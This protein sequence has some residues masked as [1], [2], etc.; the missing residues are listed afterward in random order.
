MR[1]R[2]LR[3]LANPAAMTVLSARILAVSS[4]L[5]GS[6]DNRK[7]SAACRAARPSH[8]VLYLQQP[9]WAFQIRPLASANV[10][11]IEKTTDWTRVD[12]REIRSL[13]SDA[14]DPVPLPASQLRWH[15][16]PNIL[17]FFETTD[18][19]A[20]DLD[21]PASLLGQHRAESAI[22]F[23]VG[24]KR[25]GYN[26]YVLGPSGIGKQTT[27][28]KYLEKHAK[29]NGYSPSDWCYVNNFLTADKPKF[30][31]LPAGMGQTL[32]TDVE[33]LIEDVK[34]AIP[35][36][37]ESEEHRRRV[38]EAEKEIF[39]EHEKTLEKL[40]AEAK[41]KGMELIRRPT[42]VALVIP[43]DI[44]KLSP[45]KRKEIDEASD[46]LQP[47][48]RD[49]I[50]KLPHFLKQAKAKSKA[51]NQESARSA[52]EVIVSPLKE[53]Y[54]NHPDVVSHLE[55]V[56]EDVVEHCD[57]FLSDDDATSSI[58]SL[59]SPRKQSTFTKYS[60]N[61]IVDHTEENGAAPVVIE[62]HPH[63][64]NLVGRVDHESH[65]GSLATDFTL[66]KAG[67]LHRA[68]GGFLVLRARDIL[69]QPFSWEAL[70]R[71]LRSGNI[72][73]DSLGAELSLVS[74]V[75]LRPEPIPLDVKVVLLGDRLLYYLLQAYD[76]EFGEL[77]KV[78]ADFSDEV[79]R[80]DESCRL[81]ARML[82][83]VGKTEDSRPMN[84]EAVAVMIEQAARKVSDQEK[85][86][87]HMR[88]I[89]DLVRESDYW[90]EAE[91]SN[92]IRASHVEKA[93]DRQIYRED[94]IRDLVH[95]EIRR[96]TFLVDVD[97]KRVGQVNG[98][99]VMELGNLA[100]G[101]PSRITAT[102]RL[103][104][105]KVLDI[106]R[107]VELG[108]SLHSKGVMI[109]SSLLAARYAR[110]FPLCLSA[111]LV[112]E[113][114][115]GLVEGDSASMAELCALL[116][117]LSG[118]PIR[119]GLAITGSVNQHG[120]AQAIGGVNEKIEGFYDVCKAKGLTGDQGVLIP[121]SNA[122]HL[123]LRPD[124]VESAKRGKF[125]VYTY[126]NVDDA[127]SLLTGISAGLPGENG[128]YP[129][130]SINFLVDKRLR[131][132]SDLMLSFAE[133]GDGDSKK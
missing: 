120:E 43:T 108:G 28:Q 126:N 50:Q 33:Q 19:L 67:A 89:A 52:I 73:I 54:K 2:T 110:D 1:V 111:S 95:E 91:G 4:F 36:A 83:A 117:A 18:E 129:P 25:D 16:D 116:S 122:K 71:A 42:G 7:F 22:E 40:G 27:V 127:I 85:L 131:E 113:Q 60:V 59:L 115:Y 75:S 92:I 55:A 96:G 130:D 14:F 39:N 104:R 125:A 98:L 74:T 82:A 103:G 109:I 32:V 121:S 5:Y 38:L 93:I 61:L 30:L 21:G 84:R 9:P 86:S 47:K 81:F 15:C 29:E 105:G 87:T 77:F 133:K 57:Q 88:S 13:P 26:L 101:R 35:A 53:F 41:K 12:G 118:M 23:G 76:P 97:G 78:A 58:M 62:D 106:E 20:K 17:S 123:M 100:F 65:L 51:L 124:V 64:H 37:L 119:Q 49:A 11:D 107:E 6:G 72:Q 66:I 102:A 45:E 24:I 79:D 70:K 63:Y 80:T 112:F 8:G 46:E 68:N 94:R 48:M 90:A 132:L 56:E 34:T 99:S 3:A 128:T 44:E 69:S 31:K 10:R 114:S